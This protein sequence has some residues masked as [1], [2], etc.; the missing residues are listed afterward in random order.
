MVFAFVDN[1][2]TIDRAARKRIRSHVAIGRNAG[3]TI[4]RSSREKA[5]G[6]GAIAASARNPTVKCVEKARYS[7]NEEDLVPIFYRQV[8]D[9]L[10]VVSFPEQPAVSKDLVQKGAHYCLRRKSPIPSP[11]LLVD[12]CIPPSL[13]L[14]QRL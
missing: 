11:S 7:K 3:K 2:A 6:L 4:V 12:I 10:S 14:H 9:G 13:F 8:G 1:N 5:V